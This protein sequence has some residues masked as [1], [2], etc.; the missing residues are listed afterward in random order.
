MHSPALALSWELWRRHRWGLA[1]VAAL[2]ASFALASAI[3]PLPV[4]LASANSLWLVLGLCYVIG[5][6]AYGF[7]GRLEAA[8]SG[9]PVRLFVLPV[10]TRMLVGWPM[11]QGMATAVVLWLVWDRFVLRPSGVATPAWWPAM[12]AAVVAISQTMVWLPF[13]LP[14]LRLPTTIG[15]LIVLVRAPLFLGLAGIEFTDVKDEERLLIALAGSLIPAAFLVAWSGVA[16]ARRGEDRDWL[17]AMHSVGPERTLPHRAPFASSFDAQVWYEWRVRG[18]GFVILVACVLIAFLVLAVA[19]QHQLGWHVADN[20]AFLMVPFLLAPF[21]GSWMS[22]ESIRAGALTAFAATRPMTNTALV[23]AKFRAAGLAALAAWG[24]A[25]AVAAGWLLWTGGQGDLQRLWNELAIRNGNAKTIVGC[26]SIV[27]GSILL[28]WRI[29]VVG[30]W[31]G[32]TGRAWPVAGQTLFFTFVSLQVLYELA[33]WNTDLERRERVRSA[34]PWIAGAAIALKIMVAA[35]AAQAL[36]RRGE[37]TSQMAV[38]TLLVWCAFAAAL[39]TLL[40]WLIPAELVPPYDLA[41]GVTLLIPL[42]R[43]AIAPLALGWNRHR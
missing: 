43:L 20:L 26:A 33:L 29:L 15:V 37:I 12:L 17:W 24:L 34:L 36:V 16:R 18:S 28:T 7:E 8:E 5:V 39:F 40:V 32:L 10:R 21:W 31:A 2:V 27:T 38:R 13:G 23:D 14:W 3:A 22:G 25:I 19:I 6:F 4:H 41:L 30:Q 11:L 35:W 42:S 9:F 1:G